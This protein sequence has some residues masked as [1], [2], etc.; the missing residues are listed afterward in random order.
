MM[1]NRKVVWLDT[2]T[3]GLDPNKHQL[4]QIA[5]IATDF[6]ML[7]PIDELEVKI[8]LSDDPNRYTAEA[9]H[10]NS[11]NA[12]EWAVSAITEPLAKQKL[13]AFLRDHSTMEMTSKY[14]NPYRIAEVAGQ[15]VSFD[16][17][18]L[19]VWFKETGD[20]LPIAFGDSGRFDTIHLARSLTFVRAIPFENYKLETLARTIGVSTEAQTHDALDDVRLTVAVAKK[21]REMLR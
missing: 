4:I 16:V 3:G 10:V 21:L 13:V 17:D 1:S 15:N 11:Y 2:E 14:G 20:F 12:E 18:F 19:R 5:C 8:K 6:D 9:L 7:E